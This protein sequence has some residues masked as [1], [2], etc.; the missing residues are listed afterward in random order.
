MK[1][2]F[3]YL[4]AFLC[5]TTAAADSITFKSGNSFDCTILKDDDVAVTVL[6]RSGVMRIPH[7]DLSDFKAR[8]PSKTSGLR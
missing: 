1:R 3:A 2:I 7:T 8:C 6:Y 5:A 4:T